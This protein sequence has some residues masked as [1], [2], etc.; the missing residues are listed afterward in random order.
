VRAHSEIGLFENFHFVNIYVSWYAS[1]F[2][3]PYMLNAVIAVAQKMQACATPHV[4]IY[5]ASVVHFYITDDK[6]HYVFFNQT[7]S[8]HKYT[9][10]CSRQ[11]IATYAS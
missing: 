10:R 9:C 4:F 3:Q 5:H 8:K 1:A 11:S 6:A 7:H 2:E